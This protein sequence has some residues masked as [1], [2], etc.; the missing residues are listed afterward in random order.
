[1]SLD[2]VCITVESPEVI[3][4]VEDPPEITLDLTLHPDVIIVAS[5]NMGPSGAAGPEGPE[6][7]EGP[8]GADGADGAPGPEGPEGPAGPGGGGPPTGAAGGVL[9][10]TYPNP[11]FASDLATQAELDAHINDT[12]DAHDATA[13]SFAPTG[14]IAAT[15][16]QAAIAEVGTEAVLKDTSDAYTISGHTTDRAI[17]AVA[18]SLTNGNTLRT[19]NLNSYTMDD[20]AD[21][22][23]TLVNEVIELRNIVMTKLQDDKDRGIIG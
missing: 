19:L 2:E 11:G 18:W 12:V 8:A 13:V 1:M 9:S 23:N 20:L 22:V 15:T 16:V 3:V 21:V 7:P 17:T 10:G 14:A 4:T 6:G 5:G